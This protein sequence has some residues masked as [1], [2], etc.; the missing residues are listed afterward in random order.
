[1]IIIT[2]TK[3]WNVETGLVTH[4][5]VGHSL[6]ITCL[7]FHPNMSRM[8]LY[9]GSADASVRV[10]HLK[11]DRLVLLNQLSNL[12]RRLRQ[13]ENTQVQK[14]DQE[15]KEELENKKR[16]LQQQIKNY[17]VMEQQYLR[18]CMSGTHHSAV[19]SL[20]FLTTVDSQ[21]DVMVSIA[22]EDVE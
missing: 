5:Y 3:I 6:P 8:E 11:Q 14:N 12:Q 19:V 4:K 9:S 15:G 10:W 20:C 13:L 16:A 18:K 22:L 2:I 7:K 21:R 17:Q 1:M